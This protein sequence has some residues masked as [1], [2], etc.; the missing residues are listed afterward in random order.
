[1]KKNFTEIE[2]PFGVK[3]SELY[4]F[5]YTIPDG[6][7]AEIKDG[8]VIVKKKESED[9]RI[10]N[11][12]IA[13]IEQA[14]H[15]GGGTII[16]EEK[17]DKWIAYLERQ[18]DKVVK[19]DH[20]REQKHKIARWKPLGE[21]SDIPDGHYVVGW[22]RFA[23]FRLGIMCNGLFVDTNGN[24]AEQP[25]EIFYIPNADEEFIYAEQQS[26]EW[27]DTDM[28][29]SRDNL[30]SVC[31]DWE[32]GKKTTLLP[33]VAVRARYFL[34]HLTEPKPA[35]WSEEDGAKL[36]ALIN[37][38][39]GDAL[40]YST[41][42]IVNWLKSLR[43]Q[44]KQKQNDY[45]T[46]HKEFFKFIYDRLIN[47]HK[48][49]PNVD[50]MRS[51]KERLNN[52]SFGEKQEWSEEDEE[53]LNSCISSIEESK[54]NR[55]AYKETD[56]DTS[57]D[58]EIDWLKSL[59]PSWKPSEEQMDALETAVSSLQSSALESLYNKLKKL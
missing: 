33:I 12:I 46:P 1:M 40:D 28:K 52:L 19:F 34:E 47:V 4:Q 6:Y 29:E 9:E 17:E 30:I 48:E 56:G 59:R 58:R 45:I 51:F 20:D 2:I 18:K 26:A 15:S 7:S 13:F 32:C 53:M 35:E 54:E 25:K 41:D 50:Y 37:Y 21:C 57:Y 16:P 55:Y 8:K 44:S 11:E 31:R 39:D 38:F 42:D 49:N 43:P 27:N 22:F 36:G 24:R 23:D 3:D 10:R 5:T 14:T